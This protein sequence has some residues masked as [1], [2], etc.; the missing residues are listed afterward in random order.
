MCVCVCVCARYQSYLTLCDHMNY[1]PPGSSV[2]EFSR[3]KYW[4]CLPFPA[5]GDLPDPG[6]EPACLASSCIGRQV[7]TTVLPG[8]PRFIIA[9]NTSSDRSSLPLETA[10]FIIRWAQLWKFS[11]QCW[12][13]PLWNICSFRVKVRVTR[14]EF[15]VKPCEK[16]SRR[17]ERIYPPDI[18]HATHSFAYHRDKVTILRW[19]HIG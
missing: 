8:K 18:S 14:I 1:S 10:Y 3:Q 11:M 15:E 17:P 2:L 5:P 19:T 13:W 9:F 6:F 7:F 16:W 4:S 12:I